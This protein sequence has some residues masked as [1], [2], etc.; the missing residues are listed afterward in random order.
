MTEM[1]ATESPPDSHSPTVEVI[2]AFQKVTYTRPSKKKY[3][4]IYTKF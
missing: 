3:T 1:V 2:A 4:V